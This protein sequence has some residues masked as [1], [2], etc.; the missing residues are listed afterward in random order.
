MGLKV[1]SEGKIILFFNYVEFNI[2]R[3][4]IEQQRA[5]QFKDNQKKITHKLLLTK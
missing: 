3:T 1:D 5:S 4:V 2:K